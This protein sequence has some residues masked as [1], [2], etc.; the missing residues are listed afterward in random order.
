[1]RT[2]ECFRRLILLAALPLAGCAHTD[3]YVWVDEVPTSQ[4]AAPSPG[5]YVI[6]SGDVLAIRVYN[7]DGLS[8]RGRVRPDGKIGVPLAGEIDALG[9]RPA[10]V[11]KDIEAHLKPF[12]VAPAVIVAVEEIQPLQISVLGEVAHPGAFSLTP[13]AGVLQ[14][15]AIAGGTTEFADRERIFVIR[16]R[17][18]GPPLRI[19]FSYEQTTRGAGSGVSFQLLSGDVV[20]VE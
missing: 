18:I 6:A 17:T 1:M 10:D 15:L 8:T 4:I 9:K 2:R 7:Q 19:R 12:F 5:D 3:A 14:A 13:G 11:A 20:T 16:K